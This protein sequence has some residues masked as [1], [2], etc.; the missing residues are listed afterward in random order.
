MQGWVGFWKKNDITLTQQKGSKGE[1]KERNGREKE[2][3]KVE[4]TEL[5]FEP[6]FPMGLQERPGD[7]LAWKWEWGFWHSG[8]FELNVN[9]Q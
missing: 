7:L 9:K 3:D 5:G 6:E 1:V 2:T 4:P 8:Q